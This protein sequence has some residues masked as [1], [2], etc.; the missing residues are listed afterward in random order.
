MKKISI[1][2]CQVFRHAVRHS[3]GLRAVYFHFR[4]TH[5]ALP[6]VYGLIRVKICRST[7]K[8]DKQFSIALITEVDDV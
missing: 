8:I 4:Q 3:A 2:T 6:K 5:A 1:L 7:N